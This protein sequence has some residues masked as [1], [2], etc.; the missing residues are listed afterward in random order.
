MKEILEKLWNEY[1][2]EECAVIET[3]D[4]RKLMKKTAQLHEK[5]NDLLTKDQK[6]A[7]EKYIESL[8][9]IEAVF[10]KKAF[11]KGCEFSVSFL[12]EVRNFEKLKLD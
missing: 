4:E 8:N 12:L 2:F 5:L 1:F 6:G 11:F 3:E 7:V 9:S 10:A